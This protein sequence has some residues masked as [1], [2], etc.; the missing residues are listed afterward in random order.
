MWA[1]FCNTWGNCLWEWSTSCV[2]IATQTD[3]AEWDKA[4]R[5]FW[6]R[7]VSYPFARITQWHPTIVQN[8]EPITNLFAFLVGSCTYIYIVSCIHRAKKERKKE[9]KNNKKKECEWKGRMI[10]WSL[11]MESE[12]QQQE[13]SVLDF[14]GRA[15]V[16][17]FLCLS[18]PSNPVWNNW[19]WRVYETEIRWK[20][21]ITI[22]PI[23]YLF[24]KWNFFFFGIIHGVKICT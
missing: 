15:F 10:L 23:Y 5:P 17:L 6:H 2:S 1:S 18:F 7:F 11:Q 14:P 3:W 12:N 19:F 9:R 21:E 8:L 22:S 13:S 24:T 4:I 20:F 16:F